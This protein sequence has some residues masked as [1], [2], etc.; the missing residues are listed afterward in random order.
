MES[1]SPAA[2]TAG[3]M[4]AITAVREFPP[5]ESYLRDSRGNDSKKM[6]ECGVAVRHV[7]F[8]PRERAHDISQ[9]R[10]G[11]VDETRLAERHSRGCRLGL[12]LAARQVDEVELGLARDGDG[13]VDFLGKTGDVGALRRSASA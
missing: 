12:S 9:R 7:I 11:G 2:V 6:G 4:V 5:S 3:E 13:V 1:V 10:Q 8:P